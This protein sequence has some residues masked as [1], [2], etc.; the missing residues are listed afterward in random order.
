MRKRNKNPGIVIPEEDTLIL[1]G[2]LPY[3][4]WA[5]IF[6]IPHAHRP[7]HQV[8]YADAQES[9]RW[10]IVLRKDVRGRHVSGE[11][12]GAE[13]EGLFAMGRDADHEALPVD[14]ISLE[15]A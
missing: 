15:E 9:P 13:E 1:A 6:C 11:A 4:I 2:S 3:S 5:G 12:G 7:G 10:K 8:Y 14:H